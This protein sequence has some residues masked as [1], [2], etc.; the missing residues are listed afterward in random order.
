[1]K[2]TNSVYF[3]GIV[4][5]VIFILVYTF[6]STE[7]NETYTD[8]LQEFR[9]DKDRYFKRSDD[10]PI[11]NK[12]KF[13]S[14]EYFPPSQAFRIQASVERVTDD[15]PITVR[16]TGGEEET[17]VRY[18]FATFK[19]KEQTH[20]LLLLK[21]TGDDADEKLFLPFTDKTNGFTTYGG[22]RY[23]DVE[24]STNDQV[25]IDFNF[26]YNPFC[27]Y[28]SNYTCPVPP[29]ENHLEIEILAGEKDFAKEEE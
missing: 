20:R 5:A 21:H 28:N 27:A 9:A 26:A 7:V 25:M 19:L 1:M 24:P 4:I 15:T 18:G 16:M 12:E 6:T 17:F 2:K 29:A 10:S 3:F 22:G 11:Q 8:K 13:T 14:L 23:L